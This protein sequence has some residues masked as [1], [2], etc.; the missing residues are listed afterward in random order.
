MAQTTYTASVVGCGSGGK[1]SLAAY[2]ASPRYELKAACDIQD[3]A[4]AEIESLYPGIETYPS[5]REMFAS[6]PTDVVSVSTFPPSHRDITFEA[7]ELPLK[8][9]LV[10]KPLGDTAQ[11]GTEIL[12]AVRKRQLPVVVPHSW[13]AR[14]LSQE[15]KSL[16]LKGEIGTLHLMEVQNQFWDIMNAGIHWVH[17]FLSPELSGFRG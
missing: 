10:E 13:L 9:I 17:F 1:L 6:C 8:G 5:H 11:A 7:L 4:L 15:L 12:E 3:E 16:L 14:D 2:A